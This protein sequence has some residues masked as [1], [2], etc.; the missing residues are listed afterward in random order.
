LDVFHLLSP[1]FDEEAHRRAV[2]SARVA[3]RRQNAARIEELISQ[4]E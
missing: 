4:K 1:L 3:G 2:I